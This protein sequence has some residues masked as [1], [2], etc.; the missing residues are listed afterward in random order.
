MKQILTFFAILFLTALP[1]LAQQETTGSIV[2]KLTDKE[3]NGEPLPFANVIIKGTSK[4][5]TTDFD[6]LY[7][8]NNL[9]PGT[10]TVEFSFVGYETLEVPNVEVVAGKVT[11]VN[12]GIGA[13]AASLDEVI[14]STVS[15][16]D[17]EVALLLEQKGAIE[18]KESIGAQ[19]LA[20]L[21]VSDAGTATTKISGVTSSEASGD[22]YVRGLGDRYLYST[23][24]GLP[25][26]SDDV[27]RKNID[28]NL[29]PTRIIEGVG[30]SKTYSP[31]YS[32]DQASGNVNIDSR[33]LVGSQELSA[34]ARAGI[35]TNVF[36]DGVVDNFKASPNADDVSFGFYSKDLP[37][38]TA[39][40]QQSWNTQTVDLPLNY[41]Y[42]LNGGTKIGEKFKF[43]FSGSQTIEHEY[44]QGLFQNYDTNT[45]EDYY[46]DATRYSKTI[47]T[48]GLLD[49]GYEFND[50]HSLGAISLL[51]NKTSDIVYEAGRNGEG[52][53]QDETD[54]AQ[55]LNQFVRDQNLRNTRLSVNQ[56]LGDHHLGDKNHLTWGIG[57]NIID[58]DEP[59]RIRNEI[60]FN[61]EQVSLGRQG[62]YQS[63]KS[64]QTIHDNEIGARLNDE[65]KIFKKDS[66]S[67]ILNI[68]GNYRN[69]DRDF[70]SQFFGLDEPDGT[71]L[72]ASSIDNLNSI[73]NQENVDNG[74][75]RSNEQKEDTYTGNLKSTAG[76]ISANYTINKLNF[77]VGA[78]Y[79]KD[80]I[81]V[82]YNVSNTF[83][84]EDIV[85]K[86][87][88]N[89]Y[90]SLNI[91]YALNDRN[92]LRLAASKTITLPEF[93][94]IS[95]FP[96]VDPRAQ[97]T[98]GNPDLIAS[99]AYNLDIKWELF[100]SNAQLISLT[101][102]YKQIE[103]PIQK[104]Q[105]T[106]SSGYF[107]FFN[108]SEKAEV[109]G[110]EFDADLKIL[111][112]KE[113]S[114]L[115]FSINATKMWHEQDLKDVYNEEGALV[116][117]FKY[118]NKT[119]SGLQG[120]SDWI[121]NAALNYE[122]DWERSLSANL[123]A[124]YASDKIFALGSTNNVRDYENYYNDEIIE[125]G[126]VSLNA[127]LVQ[128]LNENWNLR[129]T[130]KNLINPEIERTQKIKPI[131]GQE[132]NE[133]VFSYTRGTVLN[134]GISYKF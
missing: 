125:K 65:F 18:I 49:L 126:F 114:S 35:N 36:Q 56:L 61:E 14:I 26:P 63:R 106:G 75:L 118:K 110:L 57:A 72:R 116:R 124:N 11:E 6:G 50:N 37:T 58:S 45:L 25:I 79:Q 47:N 93:K 100:P 78:R 43:F 122:T 66:S 54:P 90:P 67:L 133:T 42:T 48:T 51:I 46:S 53:T 5:T 60:N 102:F 82:H 89:I 98:Q 88:D 15:R 85:E 77:N 81:N 40:T 12:T 119:S 31:Q 1:M 16:R 33:S 105:V 17:S 64:T 68:G 95:P 113:G 2:G 107:R 121:F 59:N 96:Y 76:Y 30:I 83:P 99:N 73:L 9:Q 41:R 8:L 32:A 129:F 94:E 97:T 128:E 130:G 20:K 123:S 80:D 24:N 120:A 21:G 62:N 134:L 39:L 132:R 34:S 13:S 10:Y 44:R 23:L 7:V 84:R 19:E 104:S 71:V 117:T 4:G 115:D 27:E 87:Y 69:K 86:S 131:G 55:D 92:N 74:S 38:Q 3:M 28:L 22:I 70:A 109:Y 29:F 52:F 108:T 101:G 127:V 103:D 112:P 91:R 111:N